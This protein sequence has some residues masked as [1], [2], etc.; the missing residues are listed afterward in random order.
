MQNMKIYLDP[1][2]KNKKSLIAYLTQKT[3]NIFYLNEDI[4]NLKNYEIESESVFI[5]DYDTMVRF[6][7][8]NLKTHFA[9]IPKTPIVLLYENFENDYF[10]KIMEIDNS[11]M[12]KYNDSFDEIFSLIQYAIRKQEI[13]NQLK[14]QKQDEMDK[15]RFYKNLFDNV[16]EAILTFDKNHKIISHNQYSET[17]IDFEKINE[18][19]EIFTLDFRR[20]FRKKLN[21]LINSS[22]ESI[23][24][25]EG[26]AENKSGRVF[27]IEAALIKFSISN[28]INYAIIFNDV[29]DKIESNLEIENLIQEMQI[30]KE[31]IEQNANEQL[32]LNSKLY[33]QQ[34]ELEQLN[35]SK[36]RFFSII[37]HDLK[38]PFQTLI[39]YSEV[40]YK[41][42]KELE[43]DEIEEFA[44]NLHT[45]ANHLF[46]LLENLLHWSR[47]QRNAVQFNPEPEDI[48]LIAEQNIDISTYSAK[49]KG[50]NLINKIKEQ[51]YVFADVNMLN[52]II[53]NLL[54][55]AIKFTPTGGNIIIDS[56]N[57]SKNV[58]FLITDSGVGMNQE[59]LDKLFR[60]DSHHTTPGTNQE[61]GTGLGLILCYD[62]VKKNNGNITVD[63]E[64]GKG[65]TFTVTL[66]KPKE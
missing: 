34:E 49:E 66:P 13:V 28:S 11:Y 65:T 14:K 46:K 22:G 3:E 27:P 8:Y 23:T 30:S 57:Q 56:V 10:A 33:E 37:A 1:L 40:L 12:I 17:I 15:L 45:S 55:N 60:I 63:S 9:D 47:I 50:I 4:E 21:N 20:P 31:I 32:I 58:D 18:I 54:S 24:T 64:I 19:S 48:Y 2:L 39:G 16:N 29:T 53:R 38:N 25:F 62:L 59:T 61:E 5:Y 26:K 41:D 52:T 35:A 44:R 43:K 42:I 36:D 7:D 51:T 6:R